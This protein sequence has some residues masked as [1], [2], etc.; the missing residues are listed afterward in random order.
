[1]PDPSPLIRLKPDWDTVRAQLD[2]LGLD[3]MRLIAA[4]HGRELGHYSEECE[5][6]P[7]PEIWEYYRR[8]PV[9]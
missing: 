6:T 2:A 9:P 5:Y 4:R 1:M 7:D 3:G 8:L